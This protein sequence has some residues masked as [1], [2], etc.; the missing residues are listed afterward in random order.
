MS[1]NWFQPFLLTLLAV[2][3]DTRYFCHSVGIFDSCFDDQWQQ[4][5]ADD[6]RSCQFEKDQN[7]VNNCAAVNASRTNFSKL[8]RVNAL[9]VGPSE[10]ILVHCKV[11]KQHVDEKSR[12]RFTVAPVVNEIRK[13][14]N[15]NEQTSVQQRSISASN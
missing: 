1:L 15:L 7:P 2:V 3:F 5:Q 10:E 6:I 11:N 9:S 4:K 14:V 13:T 8:H 12:S